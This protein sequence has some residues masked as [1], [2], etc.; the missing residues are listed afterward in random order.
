M[1][2]LISRERAF[3]LGESEDDAEIEAL[4]DRAPRAG[5]ERFV[6]SGDMLRERRKRFVQPRPEGAPDT[7]RDLVA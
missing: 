7:G 3:R 6:D 2:P 1:S 5:R 4:V